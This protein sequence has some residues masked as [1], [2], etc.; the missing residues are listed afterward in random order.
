MVLRLKKGMTAGEYE[1]IADQ[2]TSSELVRGE[3]V[4]LMAGGLEHSK[5]AALITTLLTVWALKT[6]RGQVFTNE[7]GIVTQHDPD[8]VR[9]VDVAY[10]SFKR[11]PAD[12]TPPGFSK[13]PPEL[14][15][16]IVGK[17]QGW[18]TMVAKAS[19]YL[20]M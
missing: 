7:A 20:E 19:E 18:Q 10:F 14:A 3:V 16:E 8:T 1:R 5:I 9:G 15:V 6:R 2:L 13:V 12:K 11:L 4:F 17:G